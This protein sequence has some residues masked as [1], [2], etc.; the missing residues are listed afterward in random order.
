VPELI[1]GLPAHVLLVHAV[2]VLVPLSAVLLVLAAVLPSARARLGVFLPLLAAGCLVLVPVT[3]HAGGQLRQLVGSTPLVER[4][5]HLGRQ[6]LPWTVAVLVLSV[7]VWW[8][9]RTDDPERLDAVDL[10]RD[11]RLARA[12]GA[13]MAGGLVQLA[14][15]VVCLVVAVGT[16]VQVVRIGESGSKAVWQGVTDGR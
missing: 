11:R 5:V 4:H 16:V 12:E 1:R 3:T 15:A 14:V 8:R 6:L 7:V 10:R 2:V 13:A 9:G